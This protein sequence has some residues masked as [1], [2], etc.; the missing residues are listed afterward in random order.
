[1]EKTSTRW[2][3]LISSLIIAFALIG[4]IFIRDSRVDTDIT[5]NTTRV[6]LVLTGN[7]DD[8]N[9]CQN[10]Y[11]S[12]MS[13]KDELN[14]K[15]VLKENVPEDESCYEAI[16]DL[17]K[18]DGCR[19]V[20]AASYG[21]GESCVKA[22]EEFPDAAIIHTHGS[23][24][25][26]NLASCQGRM[27]QAR[28]LSGI[29]AGMR[30]ETDSI[31]YVAAFPYSE[32]NRNLNAF[33]LGVRRVNPA[34]NVYVRF[35]DSWLDDDAAGDATIR[36]L[37]D[38][39]DIDVISMHTN[40]IRPNEVADERG[41]WSI[42][43]NRDNAGLFPDTYVTACVWSWENYYRKAITDYLRGK[44]HGEIVW[45]G[46]EDKVP[47][48]SDLTKNAV[49][50]TQEAVDEAREEFAS[51]K[52]DVFYGQINDNTGRVRIPDGESMS[53]EEMMN[54]F[55]WYVEGVIIEE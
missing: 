43:F 34:A 7:V 35:C 52:F 41:V 53:D 37:D 44:F 10:Q 33:A 26:A 8:Q 28:Y 50:G 17:I 40:S 48:L 29:A 4:M 54:H 14:L 45:L 22:A 16:R 12:L 25:S 39:P 5:R 15:I 23:E 42:G 2:M 11:E 6:G 1:M 18:K 36:L 13:L 20:A 24:S 51:R 19:V 27:Y 47:G 21:Y 46:M 31:G 38:H 9:Y 3:I 55:D 30:T 32:V 49:S